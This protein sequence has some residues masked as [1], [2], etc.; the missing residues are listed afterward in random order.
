MS[1]QPVN[2]Y[3]VYQSADTFL[4]FTSRS[5]HQYWLACCEGSARG[6][7]DKCGTEW[8]MV[9]AEHWPKVPL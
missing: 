2:V 4:V 5:T 8:R 6:V 3:R 7:V 9:P 1:T